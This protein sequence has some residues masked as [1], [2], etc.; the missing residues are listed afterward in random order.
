M[1]LQVL[2]LKISR[3]TPVLGTKERERERERPTVEL[4]GSSPP[5]NNVSL[6]CPYVTLVYYYCS[7]SSM[8]MHHASYIR[9]SSTVRL[10]GLIVIP[11]LRRLVPYEIGW[12]PE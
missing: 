11:S 2:Y 8:L 3:E 7:T 5:I 10:N 12:P 1:R 6:F 9:T 4:R